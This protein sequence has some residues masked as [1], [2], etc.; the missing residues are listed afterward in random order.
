MNVLIK[1][2]LGHESTV[3]NIED[4]TNEIMDSLVKYG[5]GNEDDE[6]SYMKS[7]IV[8]EQIRDLDEETWIKEQVKDAVIIAV[9]MN[10][11]KEDV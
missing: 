4:L 6:E 11:E 7:L 2:F 9:P 10:G 5:Y 3:E 1:I 8:I